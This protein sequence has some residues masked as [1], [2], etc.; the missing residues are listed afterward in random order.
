MV[1]LSN[2]DTVTVVHMPYYESPTQ[3]PPLCEITGSCT[4]Q[5]SL[6]L[7][8]LSHSCIIRHCR[9]NTWLISLGAIF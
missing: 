8:D 5:V 4:L 7:T 3:D 9:E 6:I 2:E 1:G